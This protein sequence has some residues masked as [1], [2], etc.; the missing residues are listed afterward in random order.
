MIGLAQQFGFNIPTSSG[1]RSPEFY[2]DLLRSREILDRVVESGVELVTP[3]G[4]TR[5][6]LTEHFE[7]DGESIEERNARTRRHLDEGVISVSVSRP[8]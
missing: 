4:V 8:R 1:E 5:V 2:Q 6:D 7:I 3:A